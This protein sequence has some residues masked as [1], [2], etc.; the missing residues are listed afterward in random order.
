MVSGGL[1][2]GTCSA[3]QTRERPSN[4]A[5]EF[6]QNLKSTSRDPFPTAFDLNKEIKDIEICRHSHRLTRSLY[7]CA[8]ARSFMSPRRSRNLDL[9]PF[10]GSTPVLTRNSACLVPSTLGTIAMNKPVDFSQRPVR[11]RMDISSRSDHLQIPQEWKICTDQFIDECF[12][13]NDWNSR[14]VLPVVVW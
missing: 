4:W 3:T 9:W 8:R 6:A 1:K 12:V 7:E 10:Q 5:R 13:D 2:P 11:W 14:T